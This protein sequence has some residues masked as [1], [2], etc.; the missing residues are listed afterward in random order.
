MFLRVQVFANSLSVLFFPSFF[1]CF[2]SRDQ[3]TSANLAYKLGLLNNCSVPLAY[4]VS[5]DFPVW[6]LLLDSSENEKVEENPR[7]LSFHTVFVLPFVYISLIPGLIGKRYRPKEH[8]NCSKGLVCRV[9]EWLLSNFIVHIFLRGKIVSN[10]DGTFWVTQGTF[11]LR[12]FFNTKTIYNII[13]RHISFQC[14]VTFINK[15]LYK[16]I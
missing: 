1:P 8:C 9:T 13:K 16:W 11:R 14:L 7:D 4:I 10:Q 15:T 12:M 3:L 5:Y 6:E 2:F